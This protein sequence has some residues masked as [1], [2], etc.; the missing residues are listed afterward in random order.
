[1]ALANKNGRSLSAVMTREVRVDRH[2]VSAAST[3]ASKPANAAPT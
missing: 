1:M 3:R 2:Q